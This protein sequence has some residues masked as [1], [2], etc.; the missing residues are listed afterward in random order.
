MSAGEGTHPERARKYPESNIWFLELQVMKEGRTALWT[1]W[2][3]WMGGWA[4]GGGRG[5][6]PFLLPFPDRP[7]SSSLD[8]TRGQRP[9]LKGRG[10]WD[11]QP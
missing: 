4:A 5:A 6:F 2:R 7:L 10:R 11:C 1:F 8:G 3:G 9:H